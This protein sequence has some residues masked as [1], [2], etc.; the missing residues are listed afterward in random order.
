MQAAE[1]LFTSRRYHESTTD[2]IAKAARVG[3]G[4]I[5]R[6]F[7]DKDD[8]FFQVATSG[9]DE[10]CELLRSQVPEEAPFGEQLLR[11]CAE[12]TRFFD[13][14]RQLFRMM[15]AEEGRMDGSGVKLKE[16]WLE[17]RKNLV[18][19]LAVIIQEG[20]AEGQVRPDVRCDVL[21]NYL[22]GMLRTRARDLEDAP[23]P[24]RRHE[25]LVD[26]FLGGAGRR[27]VP[28]RHNP[29]GKPE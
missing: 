7:A 20:V 15:I 16:R 6:Y 4:T 5:Y 8:L 28:E 13:R 9:F 22:L 18:A 1:A 12:I 26:L 14:R 29:Q 2:D 17:R 3:K 27:R 19:A 11:A 24:M 23:E 10:L 25:L 21:A